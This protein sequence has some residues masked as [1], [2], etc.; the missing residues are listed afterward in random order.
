MM[1]YSILGYRVN[2]TFF[3]CK[4][5]IIQGSTKLSSEAQMGHGI[6]VLVQKDSIAKKES[7]SCT[8]P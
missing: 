4:L 1:I 3:P 6:F 5:F 2:S 8:E 7:F